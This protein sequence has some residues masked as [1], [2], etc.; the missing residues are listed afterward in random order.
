MAAM[1][2]A[3]KIDVSKK[4]DRTGLSAS[5]YWLSKLAFHIAPNRTARLIREKV[6]AV[7]P[8]VLNARQL[9]LQA[10]ARSFHLDCKLGKIQVMEW[11][12][13]PVILLVHGWGGRALQ[14]D[15]FVPALVDKGFK[16]VAFDHKGHGES[17]TNFSS[18]LEIVAGTDLLVS[19]YAPVIYGV[20]AHSIGS[21][22][23]FKVCEKFERRLKVAVVSPMEGF[24]RWLEK[25]RR[26]LGIDENLFANVIAGIEAETGLN[27]I[28]Q[29]SLDF[30]KIGRHDV[31]LVHD[32]FDRIN[33]VTASHALHRSLPG[34]S[35]METEMLGHSRILAN[36]AVVDRVAAHFTAAV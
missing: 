11:G 5:I 13:G 10:R 22:S 33:K 9:E 17:S 3:A 25:M 20:L 16:V 21:N 24:P 34:S 27:L 2:P 36:P 7:K 12:S 19:R 23:A 28:E 35:L 4:H 29:C 26:K 14:M 32:R 31:F 30:D 18:F 6:F 1:A 8:Y 15:S